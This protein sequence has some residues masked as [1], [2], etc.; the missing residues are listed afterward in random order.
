MLSFTDPATVLVHVNVVIHFCVGFLSG[1]ES[2]QFGYTCFAVGH[3]V[4]KRGKGGGGAG[5]SIPLTCLTPPHCC[6][7]PKPGPRFPT[8]YCRGPVCVQ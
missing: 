2:V 7:C 8:S 4:I 3:P 6:A 1:I 5:G